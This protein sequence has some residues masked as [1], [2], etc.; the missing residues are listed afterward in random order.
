MDIKCIYCDANYR[1]VCLTHDWVKNVIICNIIII[2]ITDMA[3]QEHH[4]TLFT[5]SIVGNISWGKLV[6]KK[7]PALQTHARCDIKHKH[8]ILL[9]YVA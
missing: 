6:M 8:I 7:C 4:H 5:L 1:V 9:P 2:I 3:E